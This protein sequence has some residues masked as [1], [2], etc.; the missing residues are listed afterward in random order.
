MVCYDLRLFGYTR[1]IRSF[2]EIARKKYGFNDSDEIIICGDIIDKGERS[3]HLLKL[4]SQYNNFTFVM[5]NTTGLRQ[6]I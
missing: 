2:Y 1:G 6:K 4:L 5:G 3:V